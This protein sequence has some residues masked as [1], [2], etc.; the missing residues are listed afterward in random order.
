[1]QACLGGA[2]GSWEGCAKH[3]RK[4]GHGGPTSGIVI[5]FRRLELVPRV[6]VGLSAKAPQR[7]QSLKLVTI[8]FVK[9]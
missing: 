2:V 7:R 8:T 6:G 5:L 1:M 3:E 9:T 4:H